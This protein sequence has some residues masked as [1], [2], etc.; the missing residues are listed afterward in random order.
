MIDLEVQVINLLE[1]MARKKQPR[2]QQLYDSYYKVKQ[3][4]GRRPTYCG[5][6]SKWTC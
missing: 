4:L 2:K 5:V 3:E 6:T 1:E